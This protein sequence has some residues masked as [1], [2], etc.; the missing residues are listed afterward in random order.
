MPL[1][2]PANTLLEA[3]YDVDNS[4]RFNDGDSPEMVKT[5]SAGD[6]DK[7]TLSFW[8]KRGILGTLQTIVSAWTDSSNFTKIQFETTDQLTF[9]NATSGSTD[10]ALKTNRLFRDPSAWMNIVCVWDSDN[11]TAGDR[12]KM[13]IN[14]VEE[15][16]FATDTNP[17]SGL[18][19]L[20]NGNIAHYIGQEGLLFPPF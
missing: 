5:P 16:S 15:T 1:I 9:Y 17:S 7:W 4:C 8:V 2:L 19:S 14:G 6:V 11:G 3:V 10:G 18:N 13:Y 20:M 12:M